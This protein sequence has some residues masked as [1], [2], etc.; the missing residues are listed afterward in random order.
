MKVFFKDFSVKG[1]SKMSLSL[2]GG[3]AIK[4]TLFGKLQNPSKGNT[5]VELGFEKCEGLKKTCLTA[6]FELCG[7]NINI[8][9]AKITD[10]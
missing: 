2:C 3:F 9:S 1:F 5:L 4:Y 7:L 8:P 10:S 6:Y